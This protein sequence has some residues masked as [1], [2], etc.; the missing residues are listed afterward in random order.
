MGITNNAVMEWSG[1]LFY[2][3]RDL[4]DLGID[5]QSLVSPVLAG[6]FFTTVRPGSSLKVKKKKKNLTVSK[7]KK[8]LMVFVIVSS[9]LDC[10]EDEINMSFWMQCSKWPAHGLYRSAAQKGRSPH[11]LSVPVFP[12]LHPALWAL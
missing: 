7:K 3:P 4:P 6:R 9:R 5:P 8:S 1:L 10:L 2:T 12:H 11:H